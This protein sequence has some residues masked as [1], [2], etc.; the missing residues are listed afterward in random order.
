[1]LRKIKK[2][3]N[4]KWVKRVAGLLLLW[5][6]VHVIYITTDGLNDYNGKADVAIILG[7]HVNADGSLSPWLQ[8]RVDKALALYKNGRVKKIYAS[9]GIN[10]TPGDTYP[11]GDAMKNY[12][13]QHGVP[14]ADIAADNGGNNTY[15]TAK[16]F[17][18]WNA[19]QHYTSA[20]VVSQFYHITRSKYILRKLGFKNVYNAASTRYTIKDV[21]GTLRE[22]PAFYKYLLV[23]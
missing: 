4:R 7:N 8:G 9:G 13:L 2:F 17:I 5:V 1:M 21:E 16:D 11:E 20:I 6:L 12:L 19:D 23:Y 10:V 14:A 22:V 3:I 18:A 15:L